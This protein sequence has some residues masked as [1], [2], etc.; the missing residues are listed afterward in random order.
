MA[1][2]TQ[3]SCLPCPHASKRNLKQLFTFPLT[4]SVSWLQSAP[5]ARYSIPESHHKFYLKTYIFTTKLT[6]TFFFLRD[7]SIS[8]RRGTSFV[9]NHFP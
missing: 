9:L 5:H 1:M 2:G 7:S 3:S 4:S 6:L 8:V